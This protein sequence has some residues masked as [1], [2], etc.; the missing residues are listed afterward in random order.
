MRREGA[1]REGAARCQ[2][3]PARLG[4]G[5]GAR[6][7][8]PDAGGRGAHRAVPCFFFAL[9]H[10]PSS[11]LCCIS[12]LRAYLQLEMQ[13]ELPQRPPLCHPLPHPMVFHLIPA[14]PSASPA[15]GRFWQCTCPCG[16]RC[17]SWHRR[18]RGC[19]CVCVLKGGL[20]R[21]GQGGIPAWLCQ[22]HI[23][24]AVSRPPGSSQVSG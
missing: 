14:I 22:E 13:Q 19:V 21:G 12:P 15:P 7:R 24:L 5:G 1:R 18:D 11:S 23:G 3:L 9:L 4:G 17:S 16:P 2:A 8:C 20:E 6:Q 10:R